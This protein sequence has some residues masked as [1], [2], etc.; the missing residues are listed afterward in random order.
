MVHNLKQNF[1]KVPIITGNLIPAQGVSD[2]A[3]VRG[4]AIKERMVSG[5]IC[6]TRIMLALEPHGSARSSNVLPSDRI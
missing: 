6:T 1:P 2:L 3:E 5:S 4:D